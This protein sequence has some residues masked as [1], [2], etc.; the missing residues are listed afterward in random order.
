MRTSLIM[1]A[2]AMAGIVGGAA[3][4]GVW[5]IGLAV[6]ADSVLVGWIAWQRDDGEH[7]APRRPMATVTTLEQV[8]DRARAAP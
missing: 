7:V 4:I 8:F 6:I 5:C 1:L 2:S 3:L